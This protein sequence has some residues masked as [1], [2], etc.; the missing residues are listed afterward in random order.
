MFLGPIADR[1]GVRVLMTVSAVLAGVC[2]IGTSFAD[3]MTAYYASWAVF[4][5][6]IPGLTNVGPSVAVSNWFVRKRSQAVM[7]YTFGAATA[8]V[9]LAPLMSVVASEYCVFPTHNAQTVDVSL[10]VYSRKLDRA[11]SHCR[12]WANTRYRN[13]RRHVSGERRPASQ[14]PSGRQAMLPSLVQRPVS[15]HRGSASRSLCR[16]EG[17]QGRGA[18]RLLAG[19]WIP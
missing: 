18:S 2:L 5:L 15:P 6:A 8:G 17:R 1:Y 9:A 16:R 11:G 19:Q 13:V 7:F 14:R 12:R 3:S 4:G 10:G